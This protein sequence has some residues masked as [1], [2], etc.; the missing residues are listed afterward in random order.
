MAKIIKEGE[1]NLTFTETQFTGCSANVS[2]RAHGKSLPKNPIQFNT[3]EK[4]TE[5]IQTLV[6]DKEDF[7]ICAKGLGCTKIE[8]KVCQI[9]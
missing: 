9:N 6:K 1:G 3:G 8:G 7:R 4:K 5:L 2:I